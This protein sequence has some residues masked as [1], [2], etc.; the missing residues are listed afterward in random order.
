MLANLLP[1]IAAREGNHPADVL[2]GDEGIGK[3]QAFHLAHQALGLTDALA[4]QALVG[5]LENALEL[6][7]D[8]AEELRDRFVLI[9]HFHVR[10]KMQAE[11]R[12][13][14]RI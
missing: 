6:A 7:L 8:L 9:L 10:L 2:V 4:S 12:R 14:Q 11:G 5:G 13:C 3:Q 1:E